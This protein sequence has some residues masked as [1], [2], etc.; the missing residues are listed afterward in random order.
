[1][2]VIDEGAT[3]QDYASTATFEVPFFLLY[4]EIEVHKL[5]KG[6]LLQ[7]GGDLMLCK[8]SETLM[9]NSDSEHLPQQI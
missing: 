8:V 5:E 3:H 4:S 9:I 1:M 7:L 6:F 2:T